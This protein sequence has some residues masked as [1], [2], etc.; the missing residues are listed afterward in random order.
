[1]SENEGEPT[2]QLPDQN[3]DRTR[4]LPGD[5]S[6]TDPSRIVSEASH[7][8]LETRDDHF[9]LEPSRS[10]FFVVCGLHALM[11]V[12]LVL[13]IVNILS[14][15]SSVNFGSAWLNNKQ[16]II[17]AGDDD[18]SAPRL[19]DRILSINDTPVDAKY[20]VR[21]IV[22]KFKTGEPYV[23]T[24]ER[25]GETLQLRRTAQPLPSESIFF[26]LYLGV[27]QPFVFLI[28]GFV[29]F[30]FKPN[31]KLVL[32]CAIAF[33]LTAASTSPLHF[34][35]YA[36]APSA[37]V[38]I[39]QVGYFLSLLGSAGPASFR[40]TFSQAFIYCPALPKRSIL[41]LCSVSS[42]RPSDRDRATAFMERANI[43]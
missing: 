5:I 16:T 7:E 13:N 17:F 19:G 33:A 4:T 18:P 1:M 12:W 30:L 2:L 15:Q 14:V 25:N 3:E 24:I 42:L 11:A 6:V 41:D 40:F 10:R 36:E 20:K 39:W 27:L 21:Q 9:D 23:L 32:V 8:R 38:L 34:I 22:R 31:S 37:I 43:V 28:S 26:T 35:T 29:L